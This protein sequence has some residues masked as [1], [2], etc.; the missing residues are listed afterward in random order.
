MRKFHGE[1]LDPADGIAVFEKRFDEQHTG[2]MLSNKFVR[3]FKSMCGPANMIPAV[4][5]NNCNQA[6]LTDDTVTNRHDP[7]WFCAF[8]HGSPSLTNRLWPLQSFNCVR[9]RNTFTASPGPPL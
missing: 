7:A 6:L 8:F 5:A 2:A 1:I 3:V 4:T 9:C